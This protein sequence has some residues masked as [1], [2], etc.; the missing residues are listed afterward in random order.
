L[1]KSIGVELRLPARDFDGRL[2]MAD[3][4]PCGPLASAQPFADHPERQAEAA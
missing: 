3:V 4:P 2:H 1:P